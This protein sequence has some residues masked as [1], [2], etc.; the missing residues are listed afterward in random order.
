MKYFVVLLHYTRPLEE[1]APVT[2]EHRAFLDQGYD[3]GWFLV[4]GRRNPPV[5]GVIIARAP[6][7]EDLEALL[8]GDP[9]AVHGVA[10]HECLEFDPVKRH[11][12]YAKFFEA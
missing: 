2:P 1:V 6:S 10:R 9:F 3:Q 4:S 11:P 7:R 8:A 5:G 12:E